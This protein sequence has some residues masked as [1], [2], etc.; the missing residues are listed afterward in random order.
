MFGLFVFA[1]LF[2]RLIFVDPGYSFDYDIYVQLIGVISNIGYKDIFRDAITNFP[3]FYV[4]VGSRLQFEFGSV[5]IF[6]ILM[7]LFNSE[8]VVFALVGGLALA[9]KAY[10]FAR[11]RVEPL[12]AVLLLL[13]S[14]VLLE[15]NAIRL[16]LSVSCLLLA[17]LSVRDGR[18]LFGMLW[19]AAAYLAHV[20]AIIFFAPFAGMYAATRLGVGR[21]LR[22]FLLGGGVLG[23]VVFSYLLSRVG[24]SKLDDYSGAASGAVGVNL[25]SVLGAGALVLAIWRWTRT[26]R[27]GLM[28]FSSGHRLWGAVIGST[29][30]ALVLLLTLT[31]YGAVGDRVWQAAF[32]IF[33]PVSYWYISQSGWAGRDA[34]L[35]KVLLY[36]MLLSYLFLTVVRYPLSNLL[37][38]LITWSDLRFL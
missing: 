6:K 27:P 28:E 32:M 36:A 20:Q 38:P 17:V 13:V 10:A 8:R 12:A 23:A 18:W 11:L 15:S 16:A 21:W 37:H 5:L 9:L 24:S 26:G 14:A 25:V 35:M 1:V 2:A 19:F 34:I 4:D 33:V 22:V 29:A 31:S 30:F 7:S 3:Y